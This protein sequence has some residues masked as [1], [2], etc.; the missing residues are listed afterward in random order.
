MLILGVLIELITFWLAIA[1][2]RVCDSGVTKKGGAEGW[3]PP[4][5]VVDQIFYDQQTRG[6]MMKLPDVPK[7][8]YRNKL[9]PFIATNL[10]MHCLIGKLLNDTLFFFFLPSDK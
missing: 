6:S 8:A 2:M 1:C 9:L 4:G 7:V 3:L 5:A 10:L